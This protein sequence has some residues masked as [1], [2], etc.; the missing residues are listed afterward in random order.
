MSVQECGDPSSGICASSWFRRCS[1]RHLRTKTRVS[2]LR[3]TK[4]NLPAIP[5]PFPLHPQRPDRSLSLSLSLS[6]PISLSLSLSPSF[7]LFPSP[8]FSRLSSRPA[9]RQPT[10]SAARLLSL[11][12]SVC[13]SV[14]SL[15]DYLSLSLSLSLSVSLFVSTHPSDAVLASSCAHSN[16]VAPHQAPI[17]AIVGM[18]QEKPQLQNNA[19]AHQL[20][21]S[22]RYFANV[23]LPDPIALPLAG[24]RTFDM[25]MLDVGRFVHVLERLGSFQVLFATTP[26]AR[27]QRAK[28]HQNTARKHSEYIQ[29]SGSVDHLHEHQQALRDG[30]VWGSPGQSLAHCSILQPL[31]HE[32]CPSMGRQRHS[33]PP[34]TAG[35]VSLLQAHSMADAQG[36]CLFGRACDQVVGAHLRAQYHLASS[37]PSRALEKT[38][39]TSSTAARPLLPRPT[40]HIPHA[41]TPTYSGA[42]ASGPTCFTTSHQ[43]SRTPHA[44]FHAARTAARPHPTSHIPHPTPHP[45][46]HI[47]HSIPPTHTPPHIPHHIPHH[48]PPTHTPPHIPHT[49]FHSTFL[50]FSGCI[51]DVFLMCSGC[52]LDVL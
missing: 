37:W 30:R 50:M 14:S 2:L 24:G 19:A 3:P 51:L 35:Q 41:S 7:S 46:S 52:I 29:V 9:A 1:E 21:K 12:L 6:L 10:P 28:H 36:W 48:I 25:P 17:V 49:T 42:T 43:A 18:L 33:V 32:G 27:P 5:S 26:R 44:T 11:Y 31:C 20:N 40:C 47:P 23:F 45:T 22:S 8:W 15:S 13:L 16:L 39:I 34:A 4:T 38:C